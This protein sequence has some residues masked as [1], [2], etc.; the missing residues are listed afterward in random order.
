MRVPIVI[1][2]LPI[3][4]TLIRPADG[5]IFAPATRHGRTAAIPAS[6]VMCLPTEAGTKV[7]VSLA[8]NEIKKILEVEG[9]RERTA[10]S[11]D[12]AP[13]PSPEPQAL[14]PFVVPDDVA[15]TANAVGDLALALTMAAGD[16][17]LSLTLGGIRLGAD[18]ASE[19]A[20]RAARNRM[21]KLKSAVSALPSLLVGATLAALAAPFR[22]LA[23]RAE[24]E[25][26]IR[27]DA[28]KCEIVAIPGRLTGKLLR[29]P[30]WIAKAA[31]KAALA[32]KA[33]ADEA[34][35]NARISAAAEHARLAVVKQ[36]EL[37][38]LAAEAAADANRKAAN[39]VELQGKQ[40]TKKMFG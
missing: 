10:P 36:H 26:E 4:I 2:L 11:Q 39:V 37:A 24:R 35:R 30:L 12:E 1:T 28:L 15:M 14:V 27:A 19:A 22:E 8:A 13:P 5:V 18:V 21:D 23:R 20:S 29:M 7:D 32:H 38:R 3:V 16:A 33:E 34:A 6:S 25:A 40:T 31:W 17:A 9:A